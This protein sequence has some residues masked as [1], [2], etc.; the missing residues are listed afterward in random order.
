[1][2]IVIKALAVTALAA[3]PLRAQAGC[4]RVDA[5]KV[6]HVIRSQRLAMERGRF[7][8]DGG[9]TCRVTFGGEAGPTQVIV[10]RLELGDVDVVRGGMQVGR[11]GGPAARTLPGVGDEAFV[12]G[13]PS[14]DGAVAEAR[15]G[16]ALVMIQVLTQRGTVRT[17]TAAAADIARLV[18]G[19]AAVEPAAA[20][21]VADARRDA[22][23]E[24]L[25]AD[26]SSAAS[27]EPAATDEDPAD[28]PAERDEPTPIAIP[29]FADGPG[30]VCAALPER[31]VREALSAAGLTSGGAK[32][33]RAP[34][35]CIYTFGVPMTDSAVRVT[36]HYAG[37]RDPASGSALVASMRRRSAARALTGVGDEASLL[38][39]T[40]GAVIAYRAGRFSG[41]VE[42]LAPAASPTAVRTG[43]ERVARTW[44][45]RLAASSN[46][47][48]GGTR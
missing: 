44:A 1:M 2:H 47:T 25:G 41:L 34:G 4:E 45:T 21:T 23:P 46:P 42:V 14:G 8:D 37:A 5:T 28:E 29:E 10:I 27:D 16:T 15:D 40:A 6:A 39:G 18:F 9:G 3:A 32:T 19:L 38:A 31:I 11:G 35:L 20:A 17:R 24:L 30:D 36:V 13:T 22:E 7:I 26:T 48:S 33:A 43:A 12:A